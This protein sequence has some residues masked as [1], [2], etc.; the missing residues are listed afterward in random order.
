MEVVSLTDEKLR[1]AEDEEPIEKFPDWQQDIIEMAQEILE[2]D[3]FIQLLSKF[4]IH[5]YRI[6]EEFC[7]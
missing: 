7:L 3:Y 6:M 1:A 5:G 2:E 4:D